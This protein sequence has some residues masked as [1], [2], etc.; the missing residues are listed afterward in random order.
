MLILVPEGDSWRLLTKVSITRPPIRL[1]RTVSN[2]W[3]NIGVWVQGGGIQ[4]G[5]EAE[6]RF[7]GKTY[8]PNP[9]M[10]P[11]RPLADKP[12]GQTLIAPPAR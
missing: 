4:P 5:Y 12:E 2:G 3:R 7:D 1:L 10:P 8:P 11:A 9:S 6:L